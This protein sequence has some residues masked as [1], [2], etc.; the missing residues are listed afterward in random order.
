MNASG[1]F[2]FQFETEDGMNKVLNHG[3][4][5]IRSMPLFLSVWTAATVLCK[6]GI[7][8]LPVWVKLHNVP[9]VAY[10]EDGLSM[11]ATKVGNP[12]MLDSYT[13]DMCANS[14]GRNS[15][16]RAL[17]EVNALNAL[18]QEI[19]V[20]IPA[21]V[22]EGFTKT[23]IEVEYEWYPPRCDMCK[24]FGHEDHNCPKQ[25]K[26]SVQ[27]ST[28][29]DNDGFEEVKKKGR[30]RGSKNSVQI[31][32][33]KLSKPKPNF[34]YR[35]KSNTNGNNGASTSKNPDPIHLTN[36]FGVL[37]GKQDDH[38]NEDKLN[39]PGKVAEEEDV[40][41]EHVEVKKTNSEGASTPGTIGAHV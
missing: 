13:S 15:Y 20:G 11:L 10:T 28:K 14:W 33:F 12:I 37:D 27:G 39:D 38:V 1:F 8:K 5:I 29:Q 2:F 40:V 18:K 34:V 30:F 23:I 7:T 6:A 25:P 26:V 31:E 17:V 3:P 32:G 19:V 22:G 9:I 4:W 35:I 41:V 36:K 24:I 16:A 21:M